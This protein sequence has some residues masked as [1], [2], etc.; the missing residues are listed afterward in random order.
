MKPK[1]SKI[2][3]FID[4]ELFKDIHTFNQLENRISKLPEHERGDAFE[5]FAEAYFSTQKI[6]QAFEVW[7]DKEVPIS[8]RD[9]LGLFKKDMGIDGVILTKE[10]HYHAYQV[11]FRTNRTNLTWEELSTFM[12]MSDRVHK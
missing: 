4:R 2:N 8:L 7:P 5:V 3:K 1:H 9:S 10:G 12:G 11:K 6:S